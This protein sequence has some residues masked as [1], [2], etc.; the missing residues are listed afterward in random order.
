MSSSPTTDLLTDFR[1]I[2][3]LFDN[4]TKIY[5][6]QLNILK[7]S[8]NELQTNDADRINEMSREL[9]ELR[10][11][12]TGIDPQQQITTDTEIENIIDGS[13]S[14]SEDG[15]VIPTQDNHQC[16]KPLINM[17]QPNNLPA[18]VRDINDYLCQICL[19]KPRDCILEPCMHFSVCAMCVR[20]LPEPICPIC[21]R[22]I[23]FFQNVFI[24]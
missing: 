7:Q 5:K 17:A 18:K 22:T 24:S 13:V 10:E 15:M 9:G 12:I 4:E 19:D 2:I 3:E 21:R 20:L 1:K 16:Q 6:E 8:I 23:E 11:I 14:T